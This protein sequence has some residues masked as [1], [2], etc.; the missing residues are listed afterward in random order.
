MTSLSPVL[1]LLPRPTHLLIVS[2]LGAMSQ[3]SQFAASVQD[4]RDPLRDQ[5]NMGV[6][7]H[8]LL[9]AG[10][11]WQAWDSDTG[12]LDHL[13]PHLSCGSD[14]RRDVWDRN[15]FAG[16]SQPVLEKIRAE[17][18][19]GTGDRVA[20]A[21]P[22]TRLGKHRKRQEKNQWPTD[23]KMWKKDDSLVACDGDPSCW[24]VGQTRTSTGTQQSDQVS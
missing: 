17:A 19:Y 9:S 20:I 6:L 24:E 18:I 16:G 11:G 8:I 3:G 5:W 14:W 2:F 21:S 22:D 13:S 15:M 10:N 4:W 7:G 1:M 12:S 23:N